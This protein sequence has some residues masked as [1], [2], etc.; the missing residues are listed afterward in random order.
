[1]YHKSLHLVVFQQV[2]Y[3]WQSYQQVEKNVYCKKVLYGTIL[4]KKFCELTTLLINGFSMFSLCHSDSKISVLNVF[5]I[6]RPVEESAFS[7]DIGN[8]RLLFHSSKVRRCN[9]PPC[10]EGILLKQKKLIIEWNKTQL[11][12]FKDP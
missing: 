1:M 6:H 7:H 5:S 3:K 10:L 8:K 4:E 11:F 9:Y 2:N 12:S